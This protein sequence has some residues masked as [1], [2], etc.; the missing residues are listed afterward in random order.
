MPSDGIGEDR[1]CRKNSSQCKVRR[2][3]E[4]LDSILALYSR[5]QN[6]LHPHTLS[7]NLGPTFVAQVS[8]RLPPSTPSLALG[9]QFA[10]C[11]FHLSHDSART[12]NANTK[13]L[14]LPKYTLYSILSIMTELPINRLQ[15]SDCKAFQSIT[16]FPFKH[17]FC[18][19]T[20]IKCKDQ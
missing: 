18:K 19:Y 12:K 13:S 3:Y 5:L 16:D 17:G 20:C 6:R 10:P 9:I 4:A 1:L 2:I 7:Q 11:N 8:C 15:C 14:Y